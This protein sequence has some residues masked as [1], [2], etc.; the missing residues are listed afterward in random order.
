MAKCQHAVKKTRVDLHELLVETLGC[1][2]VYFQPPETMKIKY[3]CIVYELEDIT[4]VFADD[5]PYLLHDSYQVTLMHRD[6]DNPIKDKLANLPGVR[7][8]RY[9]SADNINHYIYIMYY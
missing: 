2:N 8:S 3:P 9:F 1:K 4:P 5:K 7:F 6:P